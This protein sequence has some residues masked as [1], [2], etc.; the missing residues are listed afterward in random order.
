MNF[1]GLEVFGGGNDKEERR[2]GKRLDFWAL[3]EVLRNPLHNVFQ[4]TKF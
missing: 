3:I 4:I 1:V 2:K